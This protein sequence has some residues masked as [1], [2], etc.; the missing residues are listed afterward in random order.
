MKKEQRGNTTSITGSRF[1][2]RPSVRLAIYGLLLTFVY[3]HTYDHI[4]DT[5]VYLGGDNADYY[6]L[7]ESLATGH[8][9]H[10]IALPDAPAHNHFPPGYPFILSLFMRA[11]LT[12]PDPLTGLNGLF[13][14]AALM[15]MLGQFGR[16]SKDPELAAIAVGLCMRNAHLL[17]FSTIMMSEVPYLLA[18]AT[19]LGA[20]GMLMRA[21][22]LGHRTAWW[23]ALLIAAA[24]LMVYIRTAGAASVLAIALHMAW[25][26]RWTAC[27][28]L[29]GSV[30]LSQVPWQMRSLRLGPNSYVQQ[31]LSVNPYR[32]E[33]GHMTAAEWPKRLL[34][35]L[36]RYALR[37]V[38]SSVMPWT[39]RKL[40][41]PMEPQE[42]WPNTLLVVPLVLLG[43]WKLP[44]HRA[45]V[46]ILLVCSFGVLLLWPPVWAGV[47]FMYA[48]VPFTVFLWCHGAYVLCRMLVQ[49][50]HLP[51]WSHW[52]PLV[53]LFLIITAHLNDHE[54]L[55]GRDYTEQKVMDLAKRFALRSDPRKRILYAPCCAG[56]EAD[57][58]NPYANGYNEYFRMAAW[59]GRALPRKDVLVCCRKPGLFYLFAH[60]P[61]TTFAKTLR[62]DSLIADLKNKGITH[63]VVDQMGF[64]DVG[65][66]LVPAVQRDPLKFPILHTEPAP[67]DRNK[68]TYLLGFRPTLGY[69]GPWVEGRKEGKGVMRYPDGT[70]MQAEWVNDTLN[71]SGVYHRA[72]GSRVE[73]HWYIGS[74][75]GEGRV[76]AADGTVLQE[77]TWANGKLLSPGKVLTKP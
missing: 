28:V 36:E 60:R 44:V 9:Y 66:Y 38:P 35:N 54:L 49:R 37:E 76:V 30:L 7:A 18:F 11:G 31:M 22:R 2:L 62:I 16:F 61:V 45:L 75:N 65:R 53:P 72:D 27:T 17:E 70:W 33:L 63:L 10:Y 32:P 15:I 68:L 34:T 40:D 1:W 24:V 8:G 12:G 26:R 4:R 23:W 20:Y 57:R 6:I 73:G 14:W 29:L 69:D 74:L 58:H 51:Q 77:G 67:D 56:M 41:S 71:G 43:L 3:L 50:S 19:A 13:L 59:A 39:T 21:E 64:A 52:V 47:R 46:S 25:R 42:E 55:E 5:R 48:L